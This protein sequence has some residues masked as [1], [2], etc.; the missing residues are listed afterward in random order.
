M[1][2]TL[3]TIKHV[4]NLAR[5]NLTSDEM[6][7]LT[8]EMENILSYVDML[9]ELDM[10]NVEPTAHIMSIHNVLRDDE[11]HDSFDREDILKN[12]PSQD[13]GC[14]KVPKIVE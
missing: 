14:F 9:D 12:A 3:N 2:V 5:L 7:K 6:N 13:K 11:I 10:E 4:A 1:K 8:F